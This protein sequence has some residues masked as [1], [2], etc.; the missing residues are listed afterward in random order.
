MRA[1]F[2]QGVGA[3]KLLCWM[4]FH[5]AGKGSAPY[6]VRPREGVAATIEKDQPATIGA[7]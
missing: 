5:K 4:P 6:R 3:M 1:A 7:L 2:R